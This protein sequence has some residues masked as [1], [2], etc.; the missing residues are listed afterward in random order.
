MNEFETKQNIKQTLSRFLRG[1]L[2][3]NSIALLNALGYKSERQVI[4]S[5]NTYDGLVDIH[6]PF[7]DINREKALVNDWLTVD[8]LFQL[9]GE[10]IKEIAQ[11]RFVFDNVR[12]VDNQIIESYLFLAIRLKGKEYTRSKLADTTR[13]INK[14][15]AMPVMVLFQYSNCL[16]LSLIN[17]R[18]N[19]REESRDVLEK[20]TLIKD[21]SFA[22]PLRAH[23]EILFDLSLYQLQ[24]DAHVRNFV[25]LHHAWQKTLDTSELNKKFYREVADWYFWAVKTVKFPHGG[26]EDP[27]QRNATAVIRLITR[28]IFV[29]FIKEKGLVPDDLF[30]PNRLKDVLK[31]APQQES[32]YYKAILQNLFFA[33]LNTEMGV[34]RRFRGKNHNGGMDDQYG[35]STVYRYENSFKDPAAALRLFADIPFLNG[36]L[37]EC[38][39]KRDQKLLVD[40]FSDEPRNQPVVPDVLFF[41]ESLTVDL[42]DIYGDKHHGSEKVRGL[43][44]IFNSY[45]FT[46][47]EN[48]PLEEEIALDPELLGKVFENLLA[49]YNPETGTTARKQTG[50]FYTPREIVNYMVTEALVAYFEAKLEGIPEIQ[51]KL[52]HLLTYNQEPHQFRDAEVLRLINA[53]DEVNVLDPACGS[54]AFPMG[55]LHKLVFILSKLDPGNKQWKQRQIGKAAEIPDPNVRDQV[56]ENIEKTFVENELNYGRKLYL[57]E[58]CI[59][60]VDIQPIAVQIAK[61]RFFI[62]LVVEQRIDRGQLN[63]GVRPLPNLETKFVT[64]NALI[65]VERPAQMLLHNPE[66]DVKE[67]QLSDVRTALFTARTPA[68]KLKYRQRDV[69]LRT[70][71]ARLLKSDG[72]GNAAASQLAS[73]DPYDQN[74]SANFFDPQWMFGVVERFD[75]VIGNPPYVGERGHKDIFRAISQNAWGKKYYQRK[76][77]LFY[78][79][80]HFALDNTKDNGQICLI[81]TNYF[82]TADGASKLRKALRDQATI[83]KFINF[84]EFKIFESALG[85]HSLISLLSKGH[86]PS[87]PVATCITKHVGIATPSELENILNWTDDLSDYY[88][89]PQSD[90]YEGDNCY[91]RLAGQIHNKHDPT[92]SILEKVKLQ[93]RDLETFCNIS[94]GVLTGVDRITHKHTVDCLIDENYL[95]HGVYILDN[96]E[97]ASLNLTS[98]ERNLVKPFFKN[99]DIQKY[100]TSLLPEKFVI[101]AT[102][103]LDID[104][105]P[106]IKRH[107]YN[108][109]KAI[110]ARSM[111]RGE[112]QAAL[113]LGKWWVIFAARNL[114]VFA[115]KKIVCPQR[116]YENTFGYNEIL[117]L[118]SADVYFIT[119]KDKKVDLKYVLSLLNSK[120]YYLWL[121]HKGK[122]KGEM[123]ELFYTPL[124]QIPIKYISIKEQ[125]PFIL[126][127]DT[128]I[129]AKNSNPQADTRLEEAEID[130]LVYK[131]YGL[132]NEEIAIVEG[133][134]NVRYKI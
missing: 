11:D 25:E 64:A 21:I 51:P 53:I 84:N 28:L 48:T 31:P 40:G 69:L 104:N 60:G 34:G 100:V 20:V 98:K 78:F 130:Q 87:L 92:Q 66:I 65:G 23:V 90:L 116:S 32:I 9:T 50:S 91:I 55:M 27:E 103:D 81:T 5:P 56:M 119:E 109:E 83:K 117:W 4:L 82:V 58:N 131:L 16:T 89:F 132:S 105:F 14:F 6:A 24:R 36:G 15:F 106:N 2:L 96:E 8:I 74:T 129:A 29:W 118:G 85:Q 37:F 133:S 101:Y 52:R 122:R 88:E 44:R 123:L 128:I 126:L 46:I 30:N 38:L 113:K 17:R 12:R 97:V 13:E 68:S 95:N 39:D 127:A 3:D 120:L 63:L 54:G 79:F 134:I 35:I 47:E 107:L 75:I 43:I 49:A 110:R 41:G 108:F 93:G 70:E 42:N 99:S 62:S 76:T 72:W 114:E 86:H 115:R 45:K 111:D 33:T 121:Y 1:S 125:L 124:T 57:I 73:W 19:K 80:F 102:R 7:K 71:L 26:V 59:Y 10:D 77:D 94:Q 67:K 22:D 61:L 18:L 112:M